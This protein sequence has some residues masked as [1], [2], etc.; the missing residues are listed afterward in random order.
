MGLIARNAEA[1][2]ISTLSMGSALDIMHAV[3]PPRA[4]FLD[5]PL[6]H[7]SGEPHQPALQRAILLQ[8]LDGFTSLVTPGSI[9]ILPFLWSQGDGWKETASNDGDTR[10]ER[11]ST[12]Q[13]QSEEDRW[14]AEQNS[15]EVCSA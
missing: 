10:T 15:C 2:G 14:L 1:A 12:P 5:F 4:A 7:T 6:G 11:Y 9:K 13:Y 8:A 3:N